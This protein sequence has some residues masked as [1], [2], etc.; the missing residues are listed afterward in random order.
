MSQFS[1]DGQW[2]WNGERWIATAAIVLPDL[3]MTEFERSGRLRGA[4]SRMR[5]RELLL[6]GSMWGSLAVPYLFVRTRAFREYRLWTLEQLALTAE[7]LLGPGDPVL[8]GETTMSSIS[9]QGTATRDLAVVVTAAHVLVVRIDFLDGQPRWV[10]LAARPHDVAI[11]LRGGP[12]L[13]VS[14]GAA[15]WEIRGDPRVFQPDPVLA[16]WHQ[17][18]GSVSNPA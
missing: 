4:R 14:S 17:T 8:A 2:W 6:L 5:L 13:L 7:Y 18:A 1:E 15:Q 10:V 11:E 16:A 12:T 3:P 9:W